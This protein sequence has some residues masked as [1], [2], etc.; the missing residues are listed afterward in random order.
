MSSV[1]RILTAVVLPAPLEPSSA[2]MLPRATSK[3]TPRSTLRSLYDFSRPRTLMAGASAASSLVADLLSSCFLVVLGA[4]DGAVQPL[5]L[6]VDP[7]AVGVVG[8]ER[9]GELHRV[10]AD[11]VA[12]RRAVR[13]G[14]TRTGRPGRPSI[15][16]TR[17]P[18]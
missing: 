1:D 7:L 4:R 18:W 3:S 8:E 13:R 11:E 16:I 17:R 9:L 10:V 2:K 12:H 6:L 5:A 15:F 14:R